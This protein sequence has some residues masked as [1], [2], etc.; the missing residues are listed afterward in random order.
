LFPGPSG[1]ALT[2][3]AARRLVARHV[4]TAAAGSSL[5]AKKV[6]PH[7]PRHSCAMQLLEAGVDSA[8]I[9]L[10]FGHESIRTTP[11]RTRPGRY[12][13]DDSLLSFL[14]AL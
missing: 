14:E 4:A 3:D 8:V 11:A 9:A 12:R 1:K 10:W 5:S 6:A 2:R 7:V 13:P